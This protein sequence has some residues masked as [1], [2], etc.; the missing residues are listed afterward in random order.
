MQEEQKQSTVFFR[1]HLENEDMEETSKNELSD[2]E[3][4]L[5]LFYEF[6]QKL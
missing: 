3:N 1:P 6:N 5:K 4:R 2:C